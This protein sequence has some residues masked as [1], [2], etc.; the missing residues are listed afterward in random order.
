LA[1]STWVDGDGDVPLPA[2]IE[3]AFDALT[4]LGA[5]PDS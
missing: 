1:I 4:D 3:R 2:L 5:H